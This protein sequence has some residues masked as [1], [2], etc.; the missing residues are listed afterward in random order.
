MRKAILSI[1]IVTASALG[2]CN[3]TS[4]YP[5]PVQAGSAIRNDAA[6]LLVGNGGSET[7][8][9][10][11]F[12]HSSLPAINARGIRLSPGE[13]V[14]IPVPVGTTKLYLSNYTTSRRPGAYLPNGVA[15]GF[16]RVD[17]PSIDINSPGL[18]YVATI[19][20]GQE[21]NF[22]T[23]PAGPQLI[24]LRKERPELAELKPVNFSWSN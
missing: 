4:M 15:F 18:Y 6:I 16:V 3:T 10:L 24:K 11:Q 8:D 14:A 20:P 13:V 12:V 19:F 2:A 23:R 17:T 7:I 21:R 1:V 22:E 9:Y 5:E